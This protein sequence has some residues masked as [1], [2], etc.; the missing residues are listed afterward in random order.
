[1]VKFSH[2]I[3]RLEIATILSSATS[4]VGKTMGQECWYEFCGLGS[5]PGQDLIFKIISLYIFE[6]FK[7]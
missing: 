4:L 2:S 3:K 1:M 5:T 6:K 7:T